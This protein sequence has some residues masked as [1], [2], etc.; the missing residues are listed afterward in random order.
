MSC[1]HASSTRPTSG[2]VNRVNISTGSLQFLIDNARMGF[3]AWACD[4]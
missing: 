2:L 3:G 1:C 4:A